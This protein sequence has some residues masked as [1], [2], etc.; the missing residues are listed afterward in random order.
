MTVCQYLIDKLLTHPAVRA[1]VGL[2]FLIPIS[3][4]CFAELNQTEDV[5]TNKKQIII[6][7]PSSPPWFWRDANNKPQ[8]YYPTLLRPYV[9]LIDP[10]IQIQYINVIGRRGLQYLFN[11][12]ADIMISGSNLEARPDIERLSPNVVGENILWSKKDNPIAGLDTKKEFTL[13]TTPG[14]ER[15]LRNSAFSVEVYKS[16]DQFIQMLMSGRVDGVIGI[17]PSL[18]YQAKYYGID[19]NQFHEVH[20]GY[21]KAYLWYRD[22]SIV[23]KNRDVWEAVA[24]EFFTQQRYHKIMEDLISEADKDD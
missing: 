12:E 1:I 9:D 3:L 22:D 14:M 17:R 10:S 11:G 4:T 15:R 2:L 5:S 21:V 13:A 23:A 20:I 7:V 8:G 6:A 16:S 18:E 19:V 24:K